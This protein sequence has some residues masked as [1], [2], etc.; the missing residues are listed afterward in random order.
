MLRLLV[1]A[2]ALAAFPNEAAQDSSLLQIRISVV[3]AA[4]RPVPLARHA[5][6]IGEDPPSAAPRR[7]V[8]ATDGTAE[9]RLRPG[10]YTVESEGPTVS[11]G[12][13][14]QWAQR[15]DVIAGRNTTLTLTTANAEISAGSA[16]IEGA[17]APLV[18]GREE[19]PA[20]TVWTE[21]RRATAV[22]VSG[23]D[24][25]E[26]SLSAIGDAT[27]VEVQLSP[28]EKVAGRVL[29]TDAAR[30]VAVVHIDRA[31]ALPVESSKPLPVAD[32]K[33]VA[34]SR[35]FNLSAYASSS[36][37]FEILFITPVLLFRAEMQQGRT[38]AVNTSAALR[39]VTD[40]GEWA[41]YVAESPPVLF[42]R[43]TPK[44]VESLWMKVARAAAYTQGAAIPPIRR[45]GP[46]FSRMRVLCGTSEIAPIHPFKIR[47]SVSE[48][49]AMD[50]GFYAFDPG[51]LGPACGT[52][53]LVLSS[54]KD[55]ART[56]T[57]VVNSSVIAQVWSDFAAYREK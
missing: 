43:A 26:T 5:L 36:S 55:P 45:L 21:H 15:V 35:G 37:E 47:T 8:T 40:F 42:I 9:I 52:V 32:M 46:G 12:R 11:Q 17:P 22:V 34:S 6:L 29:S 38:G 44:L 54:V 2:L 33:A 23:K 39:P 50:E 51:A 16:G 3:D 13:G 41:D 7:I 4:E 10:R 25:V 53:S 57:R 19:S 31:A 14:Y 48:T 20:A 18:P 24:V 27:S 56:E 1:F 28:A 30:D 49:E